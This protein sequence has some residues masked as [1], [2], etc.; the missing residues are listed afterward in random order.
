LRHLLTADRLFAALTV[1]VDPTIV[2][3]TVHRYFDVRTISICTISSPALEDARIF[4]PSQKTE[5]NYPW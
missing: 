5:V 1:I 4:R 3:L 2:P